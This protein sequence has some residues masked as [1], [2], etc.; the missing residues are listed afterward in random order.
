MPVKGCTEESLERLERGVVECEEEGRLEG[1]LDGRLDGRL[2]ALG[3]DA[4]GGGP[5]GGPG[6]VVGGPWAF[7]TADGMPVVCGVGANGSCHSVRDGGTGIRRGPREVSAF[8]GMSLSMSIASGLSGLVC[9]TF[10]AAVPVFGAFIFSFGT[11]ESSVSSVTVALEKG[12]LPFFRSAST[13][14]V[15]R[16]ST[17]PFEGEVLP[18]FDCG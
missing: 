17:G 12:F 7:G 18:S 13:M 9:V 14:E 6:S 1:L 8:A 5:G 3:C 4:F 16:L 11:S 15:R 10:G 2:A